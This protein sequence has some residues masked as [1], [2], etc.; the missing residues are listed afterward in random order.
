MSSKKILLTLASIPAA[1]GGLYLAAVMPRIIK[2]PSK[3]PFVGKLYAHRGLHDNHSNAPENSMAAFRKAVEAGYGIECDVQLTRDGI[4]VIFHDFTLARVARYDKGFESHYPIHNLDGSLGVRGK[5]GDYS[6]EELQH[7]HLLDSEEKIPKFED[8]LKMVD[9]KVPLIIELKIEAFDTGV[10]PVA[11]GLLR[12]YK[13]D[14]CIESFNPLGLIWYRKHHPE[15]M[16]GQLAEEFLKDEKDEFHSKIWKIPSYLLLNFITRP[17]FVAYNYKHERNMS[18]RIVRR[19]YRN[20]AAAWTIKD[21]DAL[22]KARGKFDIFIFDSFIPDVKEKAESMIEKADQFM[23]E[24][25]R[26]YTQLS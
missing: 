20:T 23:E 11:D 16:R 26:D 1:I 24:G 13:G 15:V 5:I 25:T 6:Y 21:Q 3:K 9:G 14:Y 19:L 2:K 22:D 10:C 7:F 18:R 12:S 8:F 17:D 4:P